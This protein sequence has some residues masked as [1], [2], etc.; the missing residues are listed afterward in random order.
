MDIVMALQHEQIKLEKQLT[1]IQ[2]AISALNGRTKT[3]LSAGHASSPNGAVAPKRTMSAAVRA[4]IS[5]KAK[6]RWA[7][8]WAAKAK[9]A[10]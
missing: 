3:I 4:T 8:I 5:K 9:K 6:E 7:K 10:K 1:A 2:G